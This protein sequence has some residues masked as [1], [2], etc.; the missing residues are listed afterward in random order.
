M[1]DD[2]NFP[3]MILLEMRRIKIRLSFE[4]ILAV[5]NTSIKG[6]RVLLKAGIN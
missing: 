4:F 5:D 3:V 6:I 2:V 1:G